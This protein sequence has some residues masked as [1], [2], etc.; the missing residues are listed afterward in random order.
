MID[1]Y[2]EMVKQ[3]KAD[4]E[5]FADFLYHVSS[6]RD[7]QRRIASQITVNFKQRQGDQ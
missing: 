7:C 2:C 6:C 4:A 3:G 1:P 5:D